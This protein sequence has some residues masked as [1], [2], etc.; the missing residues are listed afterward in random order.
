VAKRQS[1]LEDLVTMQTSAKDYLEV[2]KIIEQFLSGT[3]DRWAWDDFISRRRFR[4]DT[5]RNVQFECNLM[6]IRHGSAKLGHYCNEEGVLLMHQ[7]VE[8]LRAKAHAV[9]SE[10]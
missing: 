5:L 4:D 8:E 9:E 3:G 6:P 10:K 7:M 2:A 1:P